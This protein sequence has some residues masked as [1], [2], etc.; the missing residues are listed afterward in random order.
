MFAPNITKIIGWFVLSYEL[1]KT[2]SIP[3]CSRDIYDNHYILVYQSSNQTR[4]GSHSLRKTPENTPALE[5]VCSEV[6]WIA[7]ICEMH[8]RFC[9]I[10][11]LFMQEGNK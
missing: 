6:N 4:T 7:A 1:S 11:K 9:V 3:L 2:K 8:V 5:L 10:G